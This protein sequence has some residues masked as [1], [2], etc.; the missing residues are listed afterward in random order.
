MRTFERLLPVEEDVQNDGEQRYSTC[1][2]ISYSGL[3]IGV[4]AVS[5]WA[6]FKFVI[7]A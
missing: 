7:M 5:M 4:G 1:F 3:M 6:F 2:W